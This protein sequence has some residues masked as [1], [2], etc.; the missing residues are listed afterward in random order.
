MDYLEQIKK[1][2]TIMI[3]SLRIIGESIKNNAELIVNNTPLISKEIKI[4][5]TVSEQQYPIVIINSSKELD[6][7]SDYVELIDKVMVKGE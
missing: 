7:T 4:N 5:I 2:R 3:E 6:I 1:E